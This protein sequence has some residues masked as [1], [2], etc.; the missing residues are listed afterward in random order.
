[1]NRPI[2]FDNNAT[3]AVEQTVLDRMI[4]YFTME[5]GNPSNTSHMF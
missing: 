4:P 2:Y 1:M 3:T 5:Y